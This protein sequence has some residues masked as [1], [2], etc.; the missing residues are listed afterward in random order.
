M[1]DGL[2]KGRKEKREVEEKGKEIAVKNE[3]L[4]IENAGLKE[5][6]ASLERE[7]GVVEGVKTDVFDV[8][9]EDLKKSQEENSKGHEGR[10]KLMQQVMDISE[11]FQQSVTF[12][13]KRV[14]EVEKIL[15]RRNVEVKV[16]MQ[17][18]QEITSLKYVPVKGDAVDTTLARYI[19][20]Y[21]PAVPFSRL[22]SGSYMFGTKQVFVKLVNDKPVFRVGGGFVGFE[23]F[24]E[25]FAGEELEKL[26]EFSGGPDVLGG[27]GKNRLL[28]D[29]WSTSNGEKMV[30]ME[31]ARKAQDELMGRGGRGTLTL[32]N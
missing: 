10:Q 2:E 18:I 4:L 7:L 8:V 24:L 28:E 11:K 1:V 25:K 23:K 20:G 21:R 15:L 3:E 14:Q 27:S 32:R 12:G 6:N 19:Q 17:R 5:K 26:L 22:N 31:K 29:G 30:K 9:L 13:D 16:L